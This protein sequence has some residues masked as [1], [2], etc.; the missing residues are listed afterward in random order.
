MKKTR[1]TKKPRAGKFKIT[2]LS[3]CFRYVVYGRDQD[4]DVVGWHYGSQDS[5]EEHVK[6]IAAR[7]AS[8]VNCNWYDSPNAARGRYVKRVE[9]NDYL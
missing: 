5:C 6:K 3:D 7:M 4:S 1:C 8:V 2:K 9:Q